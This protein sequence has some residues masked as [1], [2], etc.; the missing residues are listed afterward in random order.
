MTYLVVFAPT[1]HTQTTPLLSMQPFNLHTHITHVCGH[2]EKDE[3]FYTRILSAHM[4]LFISC[5]RFL[6]NYERKIRGKTI[7]LLAISKHETTPLY[8]DVPG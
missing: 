4:V 1:G 8:R 2:K 7:F 6:T 3:T 5:V